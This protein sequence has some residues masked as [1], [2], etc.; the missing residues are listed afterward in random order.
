MSLSTIPS[1]EKNKIY[2]P[3]HVELEEIFTAECSKLIA[4][5][6]KE[7]A[8]YQR[9]TKLIE[10][11][12][13]KAKVLGAEKEKLFANGA[14]I[15]T[16]GELIPRWIHPHN[17]PS[18][19]SSSSPT[20]S[21]MSYRSGTQRAAPVDPIY[22]GSKTY[23]IPDL[24]P[25]RPF[26]LPV[27]GEPRAGIFYFGSRDG[28][29][30][31]ARVDPWNAFGVP[32]L[33]IAA[34]SGRQLRFDELP[35]RFIREGGDFGRVWSGE[36]AYKKVEA[37]CEDVERHRWG[38]TDPNK[39]VGEEGGADSCLWLKNLD[40]ARIEALDRKFYPVPVMTGA[41]VF[42]GGQS[43]ASGQARPADDK[44][45]NFGTFTHPSEFQRYLE[46]FTD[47][48]ERR[49][50]QFL[51][52]VRAAAASQTSPTRPPATWSIPNG[53]LEDSNLW[54]YTPATTEGDGSLP[55]RPSESELVSIIDRYD[56]EQQ[57]LSFPPLEP[58]VMCRGAAR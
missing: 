11:L 15:P 3:R 32:S 17:P 31:F 40:H 36:G 56:H 29:D 57:R 16:V 58:V 38:F 21:T 28:H 48:L 54:A 50:E 23:K 14:A 9:M 12:N 1:R 2:L 13:S 35:A 18:I 44:V 8:T 46:Q 47:R 25:R 10:I 41:P 52:E 39:P 34:G 53:S 43:E 27:A 19:A 5:F 30:A 7:P 26:Y 20:L 55:C 45:P 4:I 33:S 22:H 51:G 6:T 24:L 37:W 42:I 49:M